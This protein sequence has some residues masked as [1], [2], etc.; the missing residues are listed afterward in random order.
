MDAPRTVIL[1]LPTVKCRTGLGRSTIYRLIA[2]NEFPRQV[3]L[4]ERAVG[5]RETDID[6]WTETRP[7]VP[8]CGSV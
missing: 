1:R 3:K 4:G 8:H 6:R 2:K 7:L 5:W